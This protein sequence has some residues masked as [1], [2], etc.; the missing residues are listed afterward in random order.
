M[1]D[2]LLHGDN[3][4]I[5]T[6]FAPL[7][8]G[9]LLSFLCGQSIAWTYMLTHRGLSYSRS[10]VVSLITLP[11]IV[12]LVMSLLSNNLITAFGM[13][14]VF[15]I[16]RFRNVLRDTLDSAYLLGVI[17]LGMACG[18]QRFTTALLGCAVLAAILFYVRA[19]S[20]G[21]RQRHDVVLSLRWLNP[22]PEL[23]ALEQTLSRHCLRSVRAHWKSAPAD[24]GHHL[25]YELLMRDPD[26][27]DEL[28]TEVGTLD[29]AR[30]IAGT[31]VPDESEL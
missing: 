1:L 17:V 8:L 16:V 24:T 13:M 10:F 19:T 23:K 29:G 6:A 20:F 2:S 25:S 14:A 12:S 4:A 22:L 15:A 28:L 9:I 11:V 31:P 27:L 18:M 3:G 26:R 21:V 30:D 5:P 7:L